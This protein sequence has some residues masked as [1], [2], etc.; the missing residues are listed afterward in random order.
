MRGAAGAPKSEPTG[1]ATATERCEH[2]GNGERNARE[3]EED[4]PITEAFAVRIGIDTALFSSRA[5]IGILIGLLGSLADD[6]GKR[7]NVLPAPGARGDLARASTL[8]PKPALLRSHCGSI[9]YQARD[10]RSCPRRHLQS[11]KPAQR[12]INKMN[13]ML[14]IFSAYPSYEGIRAVWFTG[15]GDPEAVAD[16]LH[17]AR[18][19][20]AM[21]RTGYERVTDIEL[22]RLYGR[23]RSG[24]VSF[25]QPACQDSASRNLVPFWP[26]P[27]GRRDYSSGA[28]PAAILDRS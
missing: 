19:L 15:R 13:P 16:L 9:S 18:Y 26:W 14:N 20:G 12:K 22:I 7:T 2:N 6:P 1:S 28:L 5:A 24:L 10:R 27:T 25:F 23:T 21:G 17:G 4:Q 3:E 8:H 11:L